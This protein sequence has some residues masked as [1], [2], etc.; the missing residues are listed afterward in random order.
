[1]KIAGLAKNGIL[2]DA[3]RRHLGVTGELILQRDSATL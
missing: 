2:A 3:E 1:L